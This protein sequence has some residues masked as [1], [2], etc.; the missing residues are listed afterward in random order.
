[1]K[2]LKLRKRLGK[3][4]TI[5]QSLKEIKVR[6]KDKEFEIEDFEGDKDDYDREFEGYLTDLKLFYNIGA[7]I[8]IISVSFRG[9]E[10]VFRLRKKTI[11]RL[12][13]VKTDED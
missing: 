12:A 13:K 8:A 9:N 7:T 4:I 5:T 3:K 10:R 6:W 11:S 2:L 1:M